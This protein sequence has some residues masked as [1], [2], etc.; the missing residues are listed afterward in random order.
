[1]HEWRKTDAKGEVYIVRYADDVVLAFESHED[2]ERLLSL[3]SE[4]LE[5]YGLK[6]NQD[7][8]RLV[9]FGRRWTGK[10]GEPKSE[11]FEFLGFTH[12]VGKSRQGQF[13]VQRKTSRKRQNRAL[14]TIYE[15]CKRNRH[16]P[17]KWQQ[18]QLVLKLR[19]HYNYYGV[20]GNY[21]AMSQFWH[22][23][24][25]AWLRALMRRSQKMRRT[26]LYGLIDRQFALPRPHI[27]H[28]EGWFSTSPGYLLG[29]AGCGKAARPV[30]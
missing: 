14:K 30:L 12:I 17:L 10:D 22:A 13:L 25:R 24:Q 23:V 21:R 4:R 28:P 5:E 27:T 16:A 19:G 1:V 6:L 9:R 29:R 11:T 7:K 3:L 2:A 8:T 26:R 20:R 18:A 15:W